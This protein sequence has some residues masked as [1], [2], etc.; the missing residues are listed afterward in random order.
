MR[1]AARSFL[2]VGVAAAAALA[3]AS[4]LWAAEPA[5]FS[6]VLLPDTQ[7]YSQSFPDTYV[8]QTRWIR[9]HAEEENIRF[10]IHLGDIV[11]NHSAIEQEWKN[12][13]RAHA[14]LDGA[15][16]YSMLPGNH[17]VTKVDGQLTRDTTLYNR[18]F[19]PA[20]FERHAW[21]AGHLG[22][23]NDNNVCR[24]AAC[25]MHFLVVSLEYNPRDEAIRWAA[26][27]LAAHPE[28]RAILATH[29]YMRPG[30]R[31]R[32]GDRLWNQ[33][34]RRHDNVFLVVSGHVL[35]VAHQTSR[36]DRGGPVHE[37]LVDYQGLP[38]GGDGWLQIL[39]FVPDENRIYARAYSPLLDRTDEAPDRT[40]VLDYAMT[41]QPRRAKP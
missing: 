3:I 25:G 14:L 33:L 24:F 9:D 13:D 8:A 34:V 40:F 5:A 10:A 35:G 21:Y 37:V 6:V 41:S 1:S 2:R 26:E 12:A 20:R 36:N 39:R 38:N 28:H 27:V 30:A 29:C 22:D 16:P 31:D 11:Q 19:G 18:Y 15:V 32:I 23:A 7:L 4:G 17:D